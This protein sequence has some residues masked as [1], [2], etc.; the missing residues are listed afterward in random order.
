MLQH[1]VCEPPGVYEDVLLER[2]AAIHRVELD[3]GEPLPDW[4]EFEAIVAMGGPMSVNDDAELPWLT[5]E[6]GAIGEAVRAG[7]PFWGACLGVQLLAASL[8]ARVYAG[9]RP[10]VGLMPVALTD[11][12]LSDPVFA[13]LPRELLTLQWH[14]DTF[15]L[16]DGAVRLAGSPA[17]PN[18]AF[19]WGSHAYGVQFHLEVSVEMAREWA[20]VPAYAESLVR[21]L[22]PGSLPR[23]IT[24]LEERSGEILEHGRGMFSRWLDLAGP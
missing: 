17:Y 23:L 18:Q 22:G 5:R 24:E 15:D 6:K 9:P 7:K 14:G 10:E 8:G 21:V 13:G 20:E 2:G 4:R 19:R 3:E 1:I 12:A 16:P 11:E